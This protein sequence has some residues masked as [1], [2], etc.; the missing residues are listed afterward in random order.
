MRFFFF[1]TPTPFSWGVNI[2]YK[3]VF[4]LSPLFLWASPGR[5][6]SAWRQAAQWHRKV[7]SLPAAAWELLVD[8]HNLWIW[9]ECHLHRYCQENGVAGELE[10]SEDWVIGECLSALN[11]ASY[12]VSWCIPLSRFGSWASQISCHQH[13]HLSDGNIMHRERVVLI[14]KS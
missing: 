2:T 6:N 11:F 13:L 9:W 14:P 5:L 8:V 1:F 10:L 3:Y 7:A 12:F 4:S